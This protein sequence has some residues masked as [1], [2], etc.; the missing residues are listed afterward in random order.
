MFEMA[1]KDSI[2]LGLGELDLE[3][4][5]EVTDALKRAVDE[6]R[7]RYGPTKGIDE[8]RS[9]VAG[10]VSRYRGDLTMENVMITCSG[11]QGTMAAY[12]TLFDPGD[13]ILV[14][15]RFVL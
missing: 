5:K 8:L 1:T 14:P 10:K 12:Q 6:G 15:G 13:E 11:T 9:A 3:P 2:N 7:N 4:P